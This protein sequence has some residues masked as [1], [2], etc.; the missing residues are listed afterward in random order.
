MPLPLTP[1][2]LLDPFDKIARH[3]AAFV[4]G[5][6][7]GA[8]RLSVHDRLEEVP[9][10]ECLLSVFASPPPRPI[11]FLSRLVVAPE[12][13][14]RGVGRHLDEIRIC[15]AEQSGC[16]SLL[17]LVFDA[18]G[19]ARVAQL[20]VQGF[21]VRG[22]GKKDTHPKF[23]ALPAPVVLERLLSAAEKK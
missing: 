6:L 2:D 23:S 13:R 22:R 15:A 21:T 19:E 7:V 16:R 9:E 5:Q 10:A 12:Y 20:T 14:R 4:D 17:G 18:S 11:G 1:A 3:W 8:A